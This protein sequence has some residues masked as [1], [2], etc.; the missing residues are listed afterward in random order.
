[1]NRRQAF[2]QDGRT[3]QPHGAYLALNGDTEVRDADCDN[4][5]DQLMC[6]NECGDLCASQ[7]VHL[8]A[9][10]V[11]ADDDKNDDRYSGLRD[12][13]DLLVP[14]FLNGKQAHG[15]RDCGAFLSLIVNKSIVPDK[16]IR[17]DKTVVCQGI[18]AES[19]K[20]LP[21][22][23]VKI[24]SPRFGTNDTVVATAIVADLPRDIPLI[25]GNKFFSIFPK[26]HDILAVRK[27]A[28]AEGPEAKTD[29]AR[30]G[31]AIATGDY[32][33]SQTRM[34]G[35]GAHKS[36]A[37]ATPQRHFPDKNAGNVTRNIHA[38]SETHSEVSR[39]DPVHSHK[40]RKN[41]ITEGD[42]SETPMLAAEVP[43]R[44]KKAGRPGNW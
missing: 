22:A 14:V 43:T 11:H 6:S 33:K 36:D 20:R 12:Q 32:R 44:E 5:C 38:E 28:V 4:V 10:N 39:V 31:I 42:N 2:R 40:A 23:E 34:A 18:F 9:R 26:F 7:E 25:I 15:L 16:D 3:Y 30:S 13:N 35:N 41:S 19:R 1:M 29:Q 21:T 8:V 27:A 24:S 37:K 17:H